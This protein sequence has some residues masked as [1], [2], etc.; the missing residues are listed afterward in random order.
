MRKKRAYLRSVRSE[1]S[2]MNMITAEWTFGRIRALPVFRGVEEYIVPLSGEHGE[3]TA[4]TPLSF[5]NELGWAPDGIIDGFMRIGEI[6]EAGKRVVFPFWTE[7][8]LR[9]DP[10]MSQR[11]LIHFPAEKKT[12]FI[13][14]AAGGA[15]REVASMIE[16]FPAC[17]EINDAGYHAFSLNYRVGA[18]ARAPHPVEDMAAALRFIFAHAE[19]LNV[20]KEGFAVGGFSAGGHLAAAF[21]TESLGW[22]QYGLPRPAA[23][24]L[25]YPVVTMGENSH[26]ESRW[27]LLREQ[28]CDKAA[29]AMWS[30]EKQ[31]TAAYP[32][33]FLWQ[34][35]RDCSV[36]IENSRLMAD[37]LERADVTLVYETF[38][39]DVHGWG[40]GRGTPAEGWVARAVDFWRRNA[41]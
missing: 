34:C 9:A 14:L 29:R 33:T 22:K 23:E 7:E 21:G 13:L 15:Y 38:D 2:L 41:E 1:V 17:S 26:A 40:S 27:N 11:Y 16:S 20:E 24:I 8:E 4:Q 28:A 25:A 18:A 35:E 12:P 36:S 31:V 10:S 19:E 5:F 30:V 39:S 32:P 37:A 3:E 6:L